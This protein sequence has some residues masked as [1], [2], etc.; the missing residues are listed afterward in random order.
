MIDARLFKL[1]LEFLKKKILQKDKLFPIDELINLYNVSLLL[2]IELEELLSQKNNLNKEFSKDQ[3]DLIR[4]KSK[5]LSDQIELKKKEA[6]EKENAFQELYLR[7]PNI[8]SDDLPIGG[9]E[10]N[11]V[12]KTIGKKPIFNFTPKKH[13]DLNIKDFVDFEKGS[14]ISKSGFI[15]YPEKGAE[16][17]YALTQFFIKNNQQ[18]GYKLT[19]PPYLVSEKTIT[20]ASNLPRFKEEVFKSEEDNLYLVPTAEVALAGLYM[21]EIL[22]E[23]ELPIRLTS[24]TSCFRREAGG[25]G[26]SERGL[27]RIHQFE[28]VEAFV[29]CLPQKAEEEHQK[30]LACAESILNKLG[31][32][33]QVSLLATGDCSFAAYKTYDIEVWLP[34]QQEYREVASVSNCTDFQSRRAKTRYKSELDQKNHLVYT[35]NGSSLAVPRIMVALFETYQLENGIIDIDKIMSLLS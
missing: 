5:E 29:F 10:A 23:S 4:Q 18:H 16:L 28:K 12:I 2:K 3:I 25:Y 15:F 7:C 24:W 32:H 35:L 34:G 13:V 9:K 6:E 20:A 27:I 8:C 19:L 1:N 14:K 17:I 31:L 11:K 21:D 22:N 26:A 33:Y 30:M